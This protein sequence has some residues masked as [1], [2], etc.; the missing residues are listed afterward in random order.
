MLPEITQAAEEKK[1]KKSK[2]KKKPGK[3]PKGVCFSRGMFSGQCITSFLG[4][5]G[6]RGPKASSAI[7][8]AD[9][10]Q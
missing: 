8:C 9:M 1:G 4:T 6:P 10:L 7:H 3:A 5:L 2:A